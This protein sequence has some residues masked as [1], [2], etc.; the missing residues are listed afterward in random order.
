[1]NSEAIWSAVSPATASG[2]SSWGKVFGSFLYRGEEYLAHCRKRSNVESTFS[3]IKR[4]SGDLAQS[5]TDVAMVN[6]VLAKA[7]Q[8]EPGGPWRDAILP[9][10]KRLHGSNL[11]ARKRVIATMAASPAA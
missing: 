7:A 2:S 11:A 6:E 9:Q 3:M 8:R 10:T 5:K 4:K 1:L